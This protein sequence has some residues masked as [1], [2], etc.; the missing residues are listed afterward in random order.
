[1]GVVAGGDAEVDVTLLPAESPV[2]ERAVT[3]FGN[4]LDRAAAGPGGGG[5]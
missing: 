5:G 4:R 1:V 2:M 3:E